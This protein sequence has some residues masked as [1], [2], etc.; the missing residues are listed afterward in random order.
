MQEGLEEAGG[1]QRWDGRAK[2]EWSQHGFPSRWGWEGGGPEV[3][4]VEDLEGLG[5]MGSRVGS[6][7]G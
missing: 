1:R 4:G 6:V 3:G 7:A 2:D 5:S